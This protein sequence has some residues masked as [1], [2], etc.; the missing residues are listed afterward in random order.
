MTEL[1]PKRVADS[2]IHDQT[3]KVFPK[4]VI[5]KYDARALRAPSSNRAKGAEP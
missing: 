2:A 1:K 3:Y 5:A 4:E